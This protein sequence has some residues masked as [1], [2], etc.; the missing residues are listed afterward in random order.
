VKLQYEALF[1]TPI[2]LF[3]A[4]IPYIFWEIFCEE[5]N[6]YVKDYLHMKQ[7]RQIC[8]CTWKALTINESLTYFG[9]LVVSML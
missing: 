8:G 7:C 4:L 3:F 6:C 2:D 5:V 1:K 9:V